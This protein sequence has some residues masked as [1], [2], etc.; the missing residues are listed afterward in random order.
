[1]NPISKR[2]KFEKNFK[3][4]SASDKLEYYTRFNHNITFDFTPIFLL[5]LS[6]IYYIVAIFSFLVTQLNAFQG[7]IRPAI[8][9]SLLFLKFSF[10]WLLVSNIIYSTKCLIKLKE[11][12]QWIKDKKLM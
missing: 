8:S 10:Y 11:K 5:F 9:V 1:M 6:T 12:R 4:L 7:N 3:N 2:K